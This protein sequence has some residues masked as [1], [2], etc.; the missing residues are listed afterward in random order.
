V[1]VDT[2][3]ASKSGDGEPSLPARIVDVSSGGVQ[4][5]VG[6]AFEPGELLTLELPARDGELSVDV[7]ACVA[8][9]RPTGDK[10]W[11]VG[12]RFSAELSDADLAALGAARAKSVLPDSRTWSRFPSEATAVYQIIPDDDGG[13]HRTAKV[14]NISPGGVALLVD[15]DVRTGALLSAELHGPHGHAATILAFVVHVTV[16]SER[17]RVI[18][19]NFIRELGEEDLQ[20]L[21]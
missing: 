10:E 6:R 11:F 13:V 9:A 21:S 8:H 1:Q 2:R 20:A 4:L 5:V 3:V 17:E 12:C 7:L 15:H 16:Q 14:L 18:G 19:C